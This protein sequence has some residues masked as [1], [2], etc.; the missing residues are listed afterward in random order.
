MNEITVQ[1][2]SSDNCPAHSPEERSLT[3]PLN[4]EQEMGFPATRT[5]K[6]ARK[7]TRTERNHCGKRKL[8]RKFLVA[9]A[10]NKKTD[11]TEKIN[12]DKGNRLPRRGT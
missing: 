1:E 5:N 8:G 4:A 7:R 2:K 9:A 10:N 3:T 6:R 12:L 11:P